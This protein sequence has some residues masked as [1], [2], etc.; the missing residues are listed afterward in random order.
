LPDR[1]GMMDKVPDMRGMLAKFLSVEGGR[2]Y[3]ARVPGF[4]SAKLGDDDA[5]A[6]L[7]WMVRSEAT[8]AQHFRPYTPRE[9]GNLRSKPLHSLNGYRNRLLTH[10]KFVEFAG[11]NVK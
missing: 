3:L 6:L 7:N 9:I 4:A 8:S 2:D 5:A 1:S 11:K 10:L